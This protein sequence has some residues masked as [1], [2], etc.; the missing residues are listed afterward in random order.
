MATI[1][2]GKGVAAAIRGEIKEEVTAI[3]AE[4]GDV[5][6]LAVVLVGEDPASQVYVRLKKR[7]CAEVGITSID[8]DLPGDTTQADLIALIDKLNADPAV[9]GILVQLPL[10]KGLDENA[11]LDRIDPAKDVDGFHPTNTGLLSQN[12]ATL[13]ACTPAGCIE[14]CDR[15]GIDLNG[16]NAVV[17]GRSNIVGKPL[18]L[19]LLHKNATVTVTHSRTKNI[20]AVIK[21]ADVIFAAVG[22]PKMVTADMVKEGAVVIDVGTTKV[23]DKLTGDVDYDAVFAKASFITPVPGGVGPM[24]RVML[25]KNTL[26]AY[27]NKDRMRK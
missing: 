15:Y 27:K 17:I 13:Q 23:G 11:V 22:V 20:A 24:T 21:Q 26:L 3:Q 18:A 25:L 7:D 2:D 1:I 4:S 10:P 12:R 19:M 5:V 6:G 14:L 9:N 8:H 16:A